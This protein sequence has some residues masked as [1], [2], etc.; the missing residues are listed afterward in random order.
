MFGAVAII[1]AGLNPSRGVSWLLSTAPFVKIGDVSYGWYLWH[2]PVMVF[3]SSL[4]SSCP[5]ALLIAGVVAL[6][7]TYL[8]YRYVEKPIRLSRAYSGRR[9]VV[10]A[11]V[12]IAVPLV[13]CLALGASARA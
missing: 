7:P 1:V 5:T 11:A 6:I 4:I 13:L 9:A 3:T 12:C 10:L 8:S 2:W